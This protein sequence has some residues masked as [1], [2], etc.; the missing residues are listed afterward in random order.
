[1]VTLTGVVPS[2]LYRYQFAL[3]LSLTVNVPPAVK[4]ESIAKPVTPAIVICCP[5]CNSCVLA[6]WTCPGFAWV[7]LLI[8]TVSAVEIP[9]SV[10]VAPEVLPVI[11]SP[12]VNDVAS[13]IFKWVNISISNR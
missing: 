9:W 11:F 6:I 12:V 8:V 3:S 1:M 4:T 7:I 13:K 10:A 2:A 5:F